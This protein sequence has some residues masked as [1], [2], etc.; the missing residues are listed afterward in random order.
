MNKWVLGYWHNTV[1][2]VAVLVLMDVKSSQGIMEEKE[3][4]WFLEF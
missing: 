4:T 2:C 3:R 1:A